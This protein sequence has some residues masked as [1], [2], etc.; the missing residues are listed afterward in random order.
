MRTVLHLIDTW[1]PGGAE[2]VFTELVLGLDPVRFR[3]RAAVVARGWVHDT[4]VQ[5]GAVPEILATSGALDL[6]YLRSLRQRIRRDKVA[7]VHGHLLGSALYGSMAAR[8]A[9]IPAVATFHGHADLPE[10]DRL[11]SLRFRIL[12]QTAS[13]VVFVSERLRQAF[14]NATPLRPDITTV[15]P[16]GL[17]LRDCH[18]GDGSRLREG[19]G[20]APDEL[21]IGAVGNVR[22][23]KGYEDLLRA[24][25]RLALP[26]RRWR[27]VIVGQ[28]NHPPWDRLQEVIGELGLQERVLFTGFRTDVGDLLRTFDV[29]ALSSTNEGFSLSTVQAMA[30]G[31][32][33]VVTRSGGP[34]EIVRDEVDGL[35]VPPSQ[36]EALAAGITRLVRDRE[37]A[38]RLSAAAVR[39]A[40]ERFDIGIM[41]KAY[42]ALYDEL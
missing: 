41:L 36:P 20:I 29:F 24:V 21:V 18:P 25:A 40:R 30:T 12:N 34:E 32:P 23:A 28:T 14:L 42:Q 27:L 3:S 31:L 6:S 33:V 15:I 37:L 10:G 22:A 11:R 1:G 7:I 38:G 13:R 39:S 2:T 17:D 4:L 8:L 9:G 19:L 26:G 35:L 16:N 5:G